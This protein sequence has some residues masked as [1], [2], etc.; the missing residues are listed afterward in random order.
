MAACSVKV[1]HAVC[2]HYHTPS[3]YLQLGFSNLETGRIDGRLQCKWTMPY[4][5]T[6][7]HLVEKETPPVPQ[8]HTFDLRQ[9]WHVFL[10]YGHTYSGTVSL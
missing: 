8:N 1:D 5:N 6:I 7:T 9:P 4:V 2:K 3:L 10:A